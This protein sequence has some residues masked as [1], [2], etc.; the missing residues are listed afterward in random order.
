MESIT[1]KTSITSQHY[2][3]QLLTLIVLY[4]I[5]LSH[6]YLLT[7]GLEY[8]QIE[9]NTMRMI[10]WF[11]QRHQAKH[12]ALAVDVVRLSS[13]AA[14][15][16][17]EPDYTSPDG[18]RAISV[19]R[20]K[21]DSSYEKEVILVDEDGLVHTYSQEKGYRL[22]PMDSTKNHILWELKSILIEYLSPSRDQPL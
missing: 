12:D 19:G 13:Q 3:A 21:A 6:I 1:L 2:I 9:R 17:R 5:Q 16:G 20:I 7:P 15:Y 4:L 18:S 8:G 10:S 22:L 14:R 11:R